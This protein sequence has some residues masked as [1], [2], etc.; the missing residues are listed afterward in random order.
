MSLSRRLLDSQE[1]DYRGSLIWLFDWT[2]VFGGFARGA[3]FFLRPQSDFVFQ[4]LN[5]LVTE[6]LENVPQGIRLF[7]HPASDLRELQESIRGSLDV[8]GL[9]YAEVDSQFCGGLPAD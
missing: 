5:V 2:I 1:K 7:A 6:V 9:F 3:G 4:L 8:V